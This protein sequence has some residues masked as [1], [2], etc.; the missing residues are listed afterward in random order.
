MTGITA[1][2]VCR[3]SA[4]RGSA[5]AARRVDKTRAREHF[6]GEYEALYEPPCRIHQFA[7]QPPA[8][9]NST[10]SDAFFW[11]GP[12]LRSAFAAQ[13]LG[14]AFDARTPSGSA[15][16]TYGRVRLRLVTSVDERV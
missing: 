2:S 7:G 16:G 11:D 13:V 8:Y 10:A 12:P 9:Q 5:R 15:R 4:D 1:F 3:T 14:Q 6:N